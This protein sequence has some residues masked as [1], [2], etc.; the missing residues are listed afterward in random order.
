MRKSGVGR[1]SFR[2]CWRTTVG[3]L[4]VVGVVWSDAF[5]AEPVPAPDYLK[6][7]AFEQLM[8]LDVTSVSR[9]PE[10]LF[11][12]ASAIQ[13]ITAEDVRRSGATSVPEALR[14]ASNLEV[15]QIDSRQWAITARGFNN[16][17]AA[18]MLVMVDGRSVYTPLYAGVYWDVQDTMLEDVERIE[19][20]SGPGATQWGSNA[21][22]GV[23]NLETKSAKRTQGALLAA[24]AGTE[25]RH[26]AAARY[27]GQVA[28]GI[29]YRVYGRSFERAESETSFGSRG[30][31]RWR[32]TQGGFRVDG[33][34]AGGGNYVVQ[35]DVYAGTFGQLGPENIRAR[36]QN[37]LGR[38]S[39]ADGREAEWRV[40]A[41]YDH[42][43]RSIPNSFTQSLDTFDL[44]V[45]HRR[46]LSSAHEWIWGLGYRVGADDILNTPANAFL[47]AKV[48]HDWFNVFAQDEITL[49]PDRLALTVGSKVEHNDYTGFEVEPSLRLA[50]TP[51]RRLTVWAAVSRAVRI[52]SRVDRDLFSPATP[53][54]RVAGG[55]HVV[56]EKLLAYETGVRAQL[57]PDLVMG[58][59][60]YYSDYDDLRSLEPLA[61]PQ[62]FPAEASSGLEGSAA[63]AELTADW[64]VSPGWRIRTGY[65]EMRVHSEPQPGTRDRSTRD[66]I[67]RDPNHQFS[68]RSSLDFSATWEFDVAYRYV[69]AIGNQHLPSY[70]EMD[71][72]LGWQVTPKLDVSWVGK[73]LLNRRHAEF[74]TPPG[75][76][77]LE[78]SGYAQMTWRF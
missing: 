55:P 52:P 31:D 61:P 35:G 7:L 22:N 33:E 26:S 38:W 12:A 42:T 41:Y 23:I 3:W 46:R 44:D 49:L 51:D 6:K 58:L 14:L 73:N 67:A 69:A 8:D 43:H 32:L 48:T 1:C 59:A 37:L 39:R 66:S 34:P 63:G 16:V 20:I 10:P 24:G 30:S 28:P 68:L 57:R 36:G 27:G 17:F 62:L 71:A 60:M 76:R 11:E 29:Y 45:Q 54:Y 19:V 21:V 40:Q 13:V 5:A 72:R 9:R 18:K 74:N 53:P 64:K 15:A 70:S 47:P 4:A 56:A 75:R 78:R 25:L 77:Y 50:W 65:T 2:R